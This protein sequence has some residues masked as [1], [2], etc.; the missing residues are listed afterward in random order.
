MTC[1]FVLVL[2]VALLS[3]MAGAITLV[4]AIRS[5]HGADCYALIVLTVVCNIAIW[6]AIAF[7]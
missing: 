5:K 6:A 2:A 1:R 4:E 7:L 3:G